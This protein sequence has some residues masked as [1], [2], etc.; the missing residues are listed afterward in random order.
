MTKRA[1]FSSA[2][3]VSL[4]LCAAAARADITLPS[5]ISNHAV[6]QR[7]EHT[8]IWGKAAAG[9]K[10]KVSLGGVQAETFAGSNGNWKVNLDLSRIGEGPFELIVEGTNRIVVPDVLIGEVWLCSGQSN[11]AYGLNRSTGGA[12]EIARSTNSRLRQFTVAYNPISEPQEKCKGAWMVADPTNTPNF[13]A[14]SYYFAKHLQKT[15]K[16]PVGIVRSAWAGT[17]IM[18][19]I[20]EISISAEPELKEMNELAKKRVVD[21]PKLKATYVSAIADWETKFQ[22]HDHPGDPALFAAPGIHDDD[23]KKVVIHNTR[24]KA[25]GLPDAGAVWLRKT[26]RFPANPPPGQ[27][28]TISL[29]VGAFDQTYWNGKKIGEITEATA[30]GPNALRVYKIP[31]DIYQEGKNVIAIRVFTP[32]EAASFGSGYVDVGV[33]R[34][35]LTDEWLA[36]T[37]FELSPLADKAYPELPGAPGMSPGVLYNGMIHPITPC[38][39]AGVVWYQGEQDSGRPGAQ[40]QK[41]LKTLI[42]DWRARFGAQLHF[43]L[44]QL[45]NYG[46][47]TGNPGSSTWANIREAQRQTLEIPGTSLATLIDLG[48]E[49]VHPP[50]KKPAGERMAL[51]ALGTVYRQTS[52]YC[53]PLYDAM[54]IDGNQAVLSFRLAES[55]LVAKPLP[56]DYLPTYSAT[57][58]IPLVRNSPESELEGFSICGEDH[59]WRWAQA[60]IEGHTV[61]VWSP[62]VSKPVAVRYAWADNPTCNLYNGAGLPASPF[63]TG[64]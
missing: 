19:W 43:C 56:A 46:K 59:Q 18:T 52:P 26:M 7:S 62:T 49:D 6:L 23:W 48:D 39:F 13:S 42:E 50:D 32:T 22:R 25:A 47:K 31:P 21:Y 64:N 40:Y 3:I 5:L 53:G 27:N 38:T 29:I 4:G 60:R 20:S 14:V 34:I 16:T 36:K 17:P 1:I 2:M 44:C 37:E 35:P 51:S 55:G 33:A 12:E 10:V 45:P 30:P 11:M 61:I 8:A 41:M 58:K 24:F 54:K 28:P 9:E 57:E 63:Q 15:M